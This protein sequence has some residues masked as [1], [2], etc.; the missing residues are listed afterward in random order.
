MFTTGTKQ[1]P[2]GPF[3]VQKLLNQ[4]WARSPTQQSQFTDTGCG[5]GLCSIYDKALIK[6]ELVAQNPPQGLKQ[7][8]FKGQVREGG[9]Q[10]M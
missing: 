3:Q 6:G 1:D 10:G 8:I 2:M 4:T 9:L 7:N 5:E